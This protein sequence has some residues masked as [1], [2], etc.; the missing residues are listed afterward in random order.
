[1]SPTEYYERM[2]DKYL[3]T[4]AIKLIIKNPVGILYSLPRTIMVV[5]QMMH[6]LLKLK[7][8]LH[9]FVRISLYKTSICSL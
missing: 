5:I 9:F 4:A 2:I 6:W 1:M 3:E 8:V 7:E